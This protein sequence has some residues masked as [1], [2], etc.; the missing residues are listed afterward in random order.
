MEDKPG[1]WR[2]FWGNSR[3]NV[4]IVR[5]RSPSGGDAKERRG[6]VAKGLGSGGKMRA[7]SCP[8]IK[9]YRLYKS[10]LNPNRSPLPVGCGGFGLRCLPT[11][12]MKCRGWWVWVATNSS[13]HSV[14][15]LMRP[16]PRWKYWISPRRT[17]L[18]SPEAVMSKYAAAWDMEING[19]MAITW[20]RPL[21][22]HPLPT[23]IVRAAG[24]TGEL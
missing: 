4:G 23:R 20:S 15:N 8:E 22:Q 7:G 19:D 24:L 9:S 21:E 18:R 5:F 17:I 14:R 6:A 2:Y 1:I 16:R 10:S 12:R 13:S 11:F 3:N